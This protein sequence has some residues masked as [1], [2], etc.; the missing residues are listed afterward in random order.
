MDK[1]ARRL[2]R[3]TPVLVTLQGGIESGQHW[4]IAALEVAHG[5]THFIHFVQR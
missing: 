2:R 3:P 1:A 4:M 5:G